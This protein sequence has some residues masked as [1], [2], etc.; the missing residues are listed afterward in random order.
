MANRARQ[1]NRNASASIGTAHAHCPA[2]L[3]ETKRGELVISSFPLPLSQLDI[4]CV[5]S[6]L[7][8]LWDR[9]R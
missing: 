8:P 5:T 7:L 3:A 4:I 2:G 1:P 6:L 9:K